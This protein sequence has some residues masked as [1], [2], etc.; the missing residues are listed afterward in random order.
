M[1]N[2][3]PIEKLCVDRTI[4]AVNKGHAM[5]VLAIMCH[6]AEQDGTVQ[7]A[8]ETLFKGFGISHCSFNRGV[9][10]LVDAGVVEQGSEG[11]SSRGGWRRTYRLKLPYRRGS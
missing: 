2:Y 1:G 11:Q 9:K 4:A 8:R 5:L 3:L 10:V 6:L 7:A